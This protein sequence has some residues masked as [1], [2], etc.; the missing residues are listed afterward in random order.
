MTQTGTEQKTFC[1]VSEDRQQVRDS[2]TTCLGFATSDLVPTRSRDRKKE[3]NATK[4]RAHHVHVAA[5]PMAPSPTSP[6]TNERGLASGISLVRS[7][8]HS[9]YLLLDHP[10]HRDSHHG[11]SVPMP[12]TS[13][14]IIASSLSGTAIANNV[15]SRHREPPP[16]TIVLLL[17]P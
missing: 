4:R 15:P 2:K 14:A 5:A 10:P 17:S 11:K 12:R 16:L 7:H 8:L 13:D 3:K 9:P 6:R 1:C